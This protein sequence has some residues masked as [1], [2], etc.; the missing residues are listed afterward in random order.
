MKG[1]YK[2]INVK[3]GKYYL[4]STNNFDNRKKYHFRYLKQN[5]HWN[6]H[7][8]HAYNLYGKDVFKFIKEKIVDDNICDDDLLLIEQQY[9]D[10]IF[11][12]N[13]PSYNICKIAGKPPSRK[14]SH[15]VI[16][17]EHKKKIA[18]QKGWKHTKD[19]R[20][21]MS[22][23]RKGKTWEEI[24]GD[25]Q[26]KQKR[27]ETSERFKGNTFNSMKGKHLP[28]Q[29]KSNISKAL[30]GVKISECCKQATSKAKSKP[31]VQIDKKTNKE[32]NEFSSAKAA[33]I[34]L[35]GKETKGVSAVCRG[36]Q[37]T[38]HGFKWKYKGK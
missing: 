37:K 23:H 5:K 24:Y 35:M 15:P 25:E 16:T 34:H 6:K 27:K 31:V 38:A 19:A 7:L 28:E 1:I 13:I 30:K 14:G 17:E 9:I 33:E 18:M 4:G 11:K 21:K 32:V 20:Q 29:W 22:Q 10:D 8:Q 2:I 26:A 3:D 36:I 12:T